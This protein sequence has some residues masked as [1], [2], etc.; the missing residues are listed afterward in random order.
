MHDDISLRPFRYYRL[1]WKLIC[2][3]SIASPTCQRCCP[4]RRA[5]AVSTSAWKKRK[6][7][8]P[9]HFQRS[10]SLKLWRRLSLSLKLW[11]EML[12]SLVATM[13][14]L[15]DLLI[16]W[17]IDYLIDWWIG[18]L[19]AHPVASFIAPRR[20]PC[21]RG[22]FWWV[23]KQVTEKPACWLPCLMIWFL[24]GF[25]HLCG[26]YSRRLKKCG[27]RTVILAV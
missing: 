18:V 7:W 14:W 19:I 16:D 24:I 17:L 12:P 21:A 6:W 13:P 27:V 20:Q 10:R 26:R 22:S 4:R 3:A 25:E 23:G 1:A 11:S 15:V 5:S 2:V 9:P 8:W